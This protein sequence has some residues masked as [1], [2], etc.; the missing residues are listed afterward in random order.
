LKSR[1][2]ALKQELARP[3]YAE[4]F[5]ALPFNSGYFM[6]VEPKK[7]LVAEEI[8][9]QLLE[10]YSTG[11]IV[12]GNVVRLAFS[13]VPKDVLPQLVE[14]IYHACVDLDKK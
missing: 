2:D 6:C 9:Q 7:G 8:R 14:N 12:L 1:Y 5:Q 4:Y 13:A 10:K 3:E 11:V